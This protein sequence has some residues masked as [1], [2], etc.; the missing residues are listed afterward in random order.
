LEENQAG[1]E[2]GGR[3]GEVPGHPYDKPLMATV[4]NP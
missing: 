4:A 1:R 2:K 3:W